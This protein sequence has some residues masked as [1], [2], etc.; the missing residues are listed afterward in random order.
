MDRRD[1]FTKILAILGTML[2]WFPLVAPIL[3][4]LL[5]LTSQ[6][7]F[8]FDYL[9]PAELFLFALAGSGLLLWAAW[10]A[11]SQIRLV[12]WGLILAILMLVGGQSVAVATGLA[13][14]ELQLT[15]WIWGLVIVS[16]ALYSLG[17]ILVG[18]GG[19]LLVR[20]L[21]KKPL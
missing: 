13:S 16:L 19:V 2:V 1:S 14:G 20:N 18:A 9:M 8:R 12:A 21:L 5:L 3:I 11:R 10:R 17:L 6:R 4:S 15:G 7:V